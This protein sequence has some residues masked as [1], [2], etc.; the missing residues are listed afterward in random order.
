MCKACDK[1]TL[2]R[3]TESS[4]CVWNPLYRRGKE[5]GSFA[6]GRRE[7]EAGSKYKV[8]FFFQVFTGNINEGNTGRNNF[9]HFVSEKKNILLSINK[10]WDMKVYR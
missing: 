3:T 2:A 5:L 9:S 6:R 8:I 4:T 10:I 7:G 1:D